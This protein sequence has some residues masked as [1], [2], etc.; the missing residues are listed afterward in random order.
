MSDEKETA[1]KKEHPLARGAGWLVTAAC[2]FGLGWLVRGMM[3]APV[4]GVPPMMGPPPGAPALVSEEVA[5]AAALNP[6]STFIG[7][8]EPVRDVDLRVQIEGIVKEVHF[9][10]GTLVH[11]GD[12]LFTID[13]EQYQARV[14]LRKAEQAQAEAS[15]DRAERYQKRLEASDARGI[16]QADVDTARS[17][18]LQGRAAV[19]QAKANLELAE[20]DLKRTRILAPIDGRIGRTMANV[21]DFVSPSLG[22]LVRIVQVDPIRVV[23]SVTDREYLKVRESIADAEIQDALRIR[24]K[25]PTGT[26]LDLL[27]QR[28]FEN[29][30]MSAETATLPVRVRFKN[31]EG[32][33]IPNGYVTVMIDQAAPK[34]WPTVSQSAVVTDREGALVYV[35]GSDGK[36]QLRRVSLGAE[37]DGRVELRTGVDVGERVIVQGVQK[38]VPGQ[39]VQLVPPKGEV[40]AEDGR[41]SPPAAEKKSGE[42]GKP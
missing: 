35:V 38:V 33:L 2:L 30:E 32:L 5:E 21:G 12:L 24:L 41:A 6:P 40:K 16:S 1:V 7:S 25:L 31:P 19:Q 18:V 26:V 4:A 9:K 11:V 42:A 3:P 10:E 15:L 13:P 20:I 14:S 28:D 29:N 37:L 8:V 17:D 23:F 22:T 39:P 34:K 36:A 27:G